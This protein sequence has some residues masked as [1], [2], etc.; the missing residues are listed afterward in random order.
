MV[1]VD[2]PGSLMPSKGG[3]EGWRE[4]DLAA[5]PLSSG[6]EADRK[7]GILVDSDEPFKSRADCSADRT[8]VELRE[9]GAGGSVCST[10]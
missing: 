3:I 6:G 10:T 9:I 5:R 8:L 7:L 1:P 4:E 2:G